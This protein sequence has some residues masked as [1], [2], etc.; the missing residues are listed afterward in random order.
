MLKTS[1]PWSQDVQANS[2]RRRTRATLFGQPRSS[3]RPCSLGIP[4]DEGGHGWCRRS[5]PPGFGTGSRL[6]CPL[7]SQRNV[8]IRRLYSKGQ[9]SWRSQ[10]AGTAGRGQVKKARA[11]LQMLFSC[12]L[13][14][15]SSVL[16][17]S[18]RGLKWRS[19]CRAHGIIAPP[20]SELES[21]NG[22]WVTEKIEITLPSE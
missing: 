17:R 4:G 20:R 6:V 5:P 19:P 2:S 1:R 8:R 11:S 9:S 22:F 10:G 7:Q 15:M 18:A 13:P 12:D 16:G 21:L 14:V 3:Q